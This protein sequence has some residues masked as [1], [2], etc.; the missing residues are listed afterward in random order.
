M[1]GTMWRLPDFCASA[2]KR[3]TLGVGLTGSGATKGRLIIHLSMCLGAAFKLNIPGPS[4]N[5]FSRR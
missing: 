3:E 5:Q 2:P 4:D 1:T